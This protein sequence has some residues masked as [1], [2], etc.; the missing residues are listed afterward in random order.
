MATS[1]LSVSLSL[2]DFLSDGLKVK[3]KGLFGNGLVLGATFI[4]PMALVL[5]Y[6][7]AFLMGLEFAGISVFILM[8][9]L[10]PLM[11]WIGRY[12]KPLSN[13]IS[14]QMPA[15]KPIL[16]FLLV[17][18][19]IMLIISGVVGAIALLVVSIT[20]IAGFLYENATPKS[21]DLV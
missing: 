10:P 15:S 7:N 9:F 8:I 14:Y 12:R 1:F 21:T 19:S 11:A 2:S 13:P 17:F 6:P 18:A 20:L 16:I 4:P 5:F 3:K